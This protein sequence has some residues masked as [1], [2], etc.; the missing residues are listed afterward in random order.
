[1]GTSQSSGGPGSGVPMVPAWVPDPPAGEPM[2][3]EDPALQ[4]AAEEPNGPEA[5]GAPQV[6]TIPFPL[7]PPA[8]FRGARRALGDFARTAVANDMRR[9]VGHYVR[10][11]YGGSQTAAR[12]MGGTASTAGV[13]HDALSSIAAGQPSSPGSPLDPALL[14]GRSVQEVM[15]A[16]VEA[17]RPIDGTQD[18]EAAR[19]AIRNWLADLLTRFPEAD[20]LN[21]DDEQRTFAIERYTAFDVFRRFDLDVGQTIRDKAASATMALSRLKEV[22]DYVRETVAASFRRLRDAG[23]TITAGRVSQVVRDALRE[24]FQVFEGFAE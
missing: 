22:R 8:R 9:G 16:V 14:A 19:A 12:R 24:T 21:L 4:K 5:V 18:A 3:P 15:D 17:V 13:L 6:P 23:R 2:S 20:L 10:T 11:G 1:M 7:A